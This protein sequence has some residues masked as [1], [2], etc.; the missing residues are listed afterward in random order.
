MADVDGG[1]RCEML[2]AG[3]ALEGG[4][5]RGGCRV[6][7]LGQPV[8]LL[9]VEHRVAP[10]KRDFAFDCLAVVGGVG[11]ANPVG[12]DDEGAVLALAHLP[13]ML[14][15]L[16]IGQPGRGGVALAAAASV[17]NISTL[18]PL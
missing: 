3:D 8:D 17:H 11:L 15:R 10:Q 6:E 2:G 16:P 12:I 1:I 7:P 13:A 9:G 4:P 18:T 14:G 5:G